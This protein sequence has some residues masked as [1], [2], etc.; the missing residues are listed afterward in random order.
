MM[1]SEFDMDKL[2]MMLDEDL[3]D[4]DV[5]TES[6]I[7]E[8]D[9]GVGNVV[10]TEPGFIF[11]C[12]MVEFLFNEMGVV[13]DSGVE[14]GDRVSSDEVVGVVEG[15]VRDILMGER[16]ALNLLCHLSG[17]ATAT[18]EMID[19][20]RDVNADVDVAATRK[21][22]PLLR[23]FEK[24]AVKAVGGEPHR[25]NL[26]DFVLIKDNH[27][28]Y[29]ESISKA[30]EMARAGGSKKIEI[31]V[32]NCVEALEAVYAGAD[33]VML[34]N[35]SPKEVSK[36]VGVIEENGLLDEVVIE[37]SGGIEPSN[38]GSYAIKGVDL[39][40]SSYMTMKAPA[41]D[42]KLDLI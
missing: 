15:S 17:V 5:T 23:S 16:V 38:I 42:I 3:G 8:N 11:G 33:I 40:S 14:D 18:K 30:V 20:V 19:I 41:L 6:I 27:L 31:E 22:T 1:L 4:G 2:R 10:V 25:K 34:D 13:F 29:V 7:S 12:S 26:G 21:T 36:T 35:F 28:R 24:K 9:L 37:V 32:E 39:I